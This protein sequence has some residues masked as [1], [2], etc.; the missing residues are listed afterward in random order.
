MKISRGVPMPGHL[1]SSYSFLP[2]RFSCLC[3]LVGPCFSLMA[4]IH[5]PSARRLV[6]VA[7]QYQLPGWEHARQREADHRL[8]RELLV[9]PRC[10]PC[11]FEV[12][13]FLT[14]DVSSVDCHDRVFLSLKGKETFR[15]CTHSGRTSSATAWKSSRE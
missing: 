8:P 4:V 10:K 1:H 6:F 12:P 9:E 13:S 5:C 15:F 11:Y 2:S 3:W 7:H 14:H